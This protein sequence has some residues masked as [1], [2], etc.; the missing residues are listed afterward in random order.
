MGRDP[1]KTYTS[2]STIPGPHK[3]EVEPLLRPNPRRF[4]LFPIEH[5]AVW[6]MYKKAQASTWTAEEL[7]LASDAKDWA[8]LTDGERHFIKRVLGFFA[9]A[10][11]I[12]NENL[13]AN[14]MD[15]V[16]IPEARCFY[17]FQCAIENVHSETYSLL[18]DTYVRDPAEKEKLFNSIETVP[19][20]KRKAQWALKYADAKNASFAERLV[21]FAAVEGIFFSASFCSIYWLRKR[22][23]MAGLCFSNDLIARDEGLHTDFA[24][25][26]YGMLVNKLTHEQVS[27]IIC[28]AVSIEC[29]FVTD[30]LPVSLLGMNAAQMQEY[31]QFVADRLMVALGCDKIYRASN[32]YP[33]M[34]SI[35]IDGK[36]NFFEK[37]VPE[38]S[39]AGFGVKEERGNAVV[40]LVF[41]DAAEF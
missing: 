4:V 11:G 1:K 28:D 13:A 30:A 35:S 25:L 18:I 8:K 7:D 16:Q 34:T 9:G 3:M 5:E 21:A 2:V 31:V 6:R 14:F 12:V 33:W 36:T 40:G 26:L 19:C 24:C 23:L 37:R 27:Q 39:K 22:G 20:I 32:P 15:E 10:D 17:A 29:D 41:D 38:Y